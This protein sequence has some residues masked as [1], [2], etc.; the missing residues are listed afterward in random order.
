ML[1]HLQTNRVLFISDK[2][3]LELI[4]LLKQLIHLLGF[5]LSLVKLVA[6]DVSCN[7]L[8]MLLAIGVGEGFDALRNNQPLV[9]RQSDGAAYFLGGRLGDDYKVHGLDAPIAVLW[10]DGFDFADEGRFVFGGKLMSN[11][12]GNEGVCLCAV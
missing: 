8:R 11:N 1:K 10:R 9:I 4:Q 6:S 12:A 7:R 3:S 5:S 2:I